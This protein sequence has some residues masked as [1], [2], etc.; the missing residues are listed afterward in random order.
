MF[1][2]HTSKMLLVVM[3]C[4]VNDLVLTFAGSAATLEHSLGPFLTTT[5]GNPTCTSWLRIYAFAIHNN[6]PS[7]TRIPHF[8]TGLATLSF[9][10]YRIITTLMIESP[11]CTILVLI[12]AFGIYVAIHK[13]FSVF[14]YINT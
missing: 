11:I 5:I 9:H 6:V 1:V 2:R 7:T 12:Y 8:H 10:G 14:R 3:R 4:T 13:Q